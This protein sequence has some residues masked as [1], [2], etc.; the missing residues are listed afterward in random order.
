MWVWPLPPRG[1][2]ALVCEWPEKKIGLTR[3][4]IDADVIVD[5]A[6]GAQVLWLR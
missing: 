3:S 5:A 4:E 1:P 6:K 2:L